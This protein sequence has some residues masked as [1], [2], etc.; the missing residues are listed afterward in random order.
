MADIV[1]PNIKEASV[2]LNNVP[3]KSVS[4]MRIAAK[5]IRD[6]GPRCVAV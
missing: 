6:L 2:L 1:T 4:D 3:L 5:L